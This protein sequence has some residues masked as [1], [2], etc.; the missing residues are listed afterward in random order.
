MC[1]SHVVNA[2]SNRS[3][4]VN[5]VEDDDSFESMQMPFILYTQITE[6]IESSI[7]S[8]AMGLPIESLEMIEPVENNE[9]NN[10]DEM[11]Q[12]IMQ[13]LVNEVPVRT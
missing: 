8:S 7:E 5:V 10:V 11:L 4:V 1:R 12:E 6:P 9:Y 2:N 13:I 3:K